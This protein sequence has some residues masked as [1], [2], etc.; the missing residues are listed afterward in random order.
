MPFGIK[1]KEVFVYKGKQYVYDEDNMCA[2]IFRGY[3]RENKPI[4]NPKK[5]IPLNESIKI[6]MKDIMEM[7]E[8]VLKS[9][10]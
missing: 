1:D 4:F 6:G 8:R 7:V 5:P 3:N 10:L 9:I 2:Y